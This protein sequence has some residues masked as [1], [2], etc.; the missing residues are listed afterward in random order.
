MITE[1][2]PNFFLMKIPLPGNPLKA[3]NCYLIKAPKRNLIIDTGMN[4]FE[5]LQAIVA[6]FKELKIDPK[7]T[8][9]FITHMHA[10]HSGLAGELYAGGSKVY[11]SRQDG[12]IIA[13]GDQWEEICNYAQMSGFPEDELQE[14][15]A[16]HPGRKYCSQGQL[17]P[18]FLKEEDLINI[19][20]YLFKC[21]ATPGHTWGHLC[22]YE[23]A[24]KVFVAGDHL[25]LDITPNI[26]LWSGHGNP[27]GVY[28]ESL[29]KVNKLDIRLV[30]PGHGKIFKNYAQRI[31]EIKQHHRLRLQEVIHALETGR[32]DAFQIASMMTWEVAFD[33]DSFPVWQ[34]W[35]AVGE[36]NAH[37]RYLEEK[38]FVQKRLTGKKIEFILK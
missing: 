36:A 26:S 4:R 32:R 10:D 13:N 16:G 5:C 19:G 11:C 34:K 14:A 35:F 30:L 22:L 7:E 27:L 8:D 21:V 17:V 23:T 9:I 6:G 29:D 25:L 3:T 2:L 24:K 1:I 12:R 37:L 15:F 20:G 38:G 18:C 31:Q 33:W 28:L